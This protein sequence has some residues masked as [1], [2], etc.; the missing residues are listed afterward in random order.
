LETVKTAISVN[1]ALYEQAEA[2]ARELGVSRS[3]LYSLALE[4][5]IRRRENRVLLERI[6]AAYAEDAGA[7]PSAALTQARRLED[8]AG[9]GGR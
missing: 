3:R 8:P 2:L 1:G 5:Y 6:N 4:D 7:D 9:E